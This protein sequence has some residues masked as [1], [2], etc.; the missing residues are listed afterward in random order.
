MGRGPQLSTNRITVMDI[1]YYLHRGRDFDFIHR[2][3]PSV[4]REEF[5]AVMVYVNEHREELIEEDRLIDE[6]HQRLK[7]EQKAK[8]LYREIDDSVP[9]EQRIEQLRQKLR[10]WQAEQAEKNGG[11]SAR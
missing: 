1:F 5:D 2:A 11:L 7:E 4:T 6:Y 10:R 9:R 8:G 3:M